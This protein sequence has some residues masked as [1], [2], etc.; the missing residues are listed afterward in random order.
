MNE[1]K[2]T[3]RKE[4][5][6]VMF[7]GYLHANGQPQLKRWWGDHRDYTDDCA[8]NEFVLRVVEPFEAASREDAARILN[9]RLGLES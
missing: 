4:I 9:E 7:W 8:G 5:D 6:V 2:R 3:P 1:D